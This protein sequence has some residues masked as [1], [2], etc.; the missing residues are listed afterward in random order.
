MER[1]AATGRGDSPG[2]ALPAALRAVQP[3]ARSHR[4]RRVVSLHDGLRLHDGARGWR[5]AADAAGARYSP[6]HSSPRLPP[7]VRARTG[8]SVPT[9]KHGPRNGV[10]VDDLHRAGVEHDVLVLLVA[11]IRAAGFGCG[12]AFVEDVLVATFL[13]ARPLLRRNL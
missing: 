7:G 4:L 5:R 9:P 12:R 10:C 1:P 13:P 11:E 3:G 6:K 2:G 8:S